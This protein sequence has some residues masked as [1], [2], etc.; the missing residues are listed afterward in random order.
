MSVAIELKNG[1][2]ALVQTGRHEPAGIKW[3]V[4]FSAELIVQNDPKG[5]VC[6]LSLKGVDF[7]EFDPRY[8]LEAENLYIAE[9]YALM[10]IDAIPV[11]RS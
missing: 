7:A 8:Q 9:D 6:G 10:I 1:M 3:S 11:N 5:K 4:P 2:K